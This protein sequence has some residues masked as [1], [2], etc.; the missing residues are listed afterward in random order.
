LLLENISFHSHDF[1]QE[2]WQFFTAQNLNPY[3]IFRYLLKYAP[4]FQ[5]RRQFGNLDIFDFDILFFTNF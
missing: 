5:T 1:R 3:S 4:A 2:M